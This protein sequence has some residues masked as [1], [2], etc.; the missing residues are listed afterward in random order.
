MRIGQRVIIDRG[1]NSESR[2][3]IVGSGFMQNPNLVSAY[4]VKL[5][6]EYCGYINKSSYISVVAVHPDNIELESEDNE[7][8]DSPSC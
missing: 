8:F 2:G 5:D 3:R 1:C 4:L 7:Y 6:Q